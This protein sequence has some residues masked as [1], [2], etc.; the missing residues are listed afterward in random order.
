[1]SLTLR[2]HGRL[3]Y[4]R[5]TVPMRQ[6]DGKITKVRIEDPTGTESKTRA[7]RVA[8]DLWDYYQEQAYR[9]KPKVV[10]FTDAAITFTETKQPSKR[11]RE[12]LAKLIEHFGELPI[13]QL[14]QTAMAEACTALYPEGAKASTLHRAVYAP[15]IAVLRMAGVTTR[16]EKPKIAKVPLKIPDDEWFKR[17]LP[18]CSPRLAGLLI[19]LSLTGRRITE[20]L[21][22]TLNDDGKTVTIARTK[23]GRPVSIKVPPAVLSILGNEITERQRGSKLFGYGDR[24]N[25]YRELRRVCRVAG[26]PYYGSHALGRHSFATRLLKNGYSTKFVAQAGGWASTRMVDM[27]YGHLEHDPVQDEALKGGEDW[28]NGRG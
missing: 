7:A 8:Q 1:M 25:V 15:T 14:D 3:W 19:F 12:F 17:L 10:T 23:S 28:L 16:F 26:I 18:H 4:A 9:P 27:V 24:H 2:K 21:E 22:A 5:G 11:D 20:A 13:S 6:P